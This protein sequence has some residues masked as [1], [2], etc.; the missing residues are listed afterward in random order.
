MRGPRTPR[1][2]GASRL[3]GT[4]GASIGG[5][6]DRDF[7]RRGD[8]FR[9]G[10]GFGGPRGFFGRRFGF[11][12]G[13]GFDGDFDYDP[14]DFENDR[15]EERREV[16]REGGRP[17]SRNSYIVRFPSSRSQAS[18]NPRVYDVRETPDGSVEM[19]PI[20]P[21]ESP[22]ASPTPAVDYW[23]I[24]LHGGLIYAVERYEQRDQTLRFDTLKGEEFVVPSAELDRVLTKRLN[25]D[26]GRPFDLR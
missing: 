20:V 15:D 13:F 11:G 2:P 19:T 9:Q 4:P 14:G 10:R 26:L 6:S 17:E 22:A 25:A 18:P 24:A 23:L 21:G 16:E 7:G 3:P 8:R 5:D 1:S 12:G